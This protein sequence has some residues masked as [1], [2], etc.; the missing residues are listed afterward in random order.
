MLAEGGV[1]DA[2]PNSYLVP[3]DVHRSGH[4]LLDRKSNLLLTQPGS[5]VPFPVDHQDVV[6]ATHV[7]VGSRCV[8]EVGMAGPLAD[9]L[10]QDIVY[11][12][13]DLVTHT[14][15]HGLS[16]ILQNLDSGH[17]ILNSLG[18]IGHI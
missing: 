2:V 17:V 4:G 7:Q 15:L 1:V 6:E 3:V 8:P 9:N 16:D 13:D 12:L 11:D 10:L 18:N 5:P 14:A